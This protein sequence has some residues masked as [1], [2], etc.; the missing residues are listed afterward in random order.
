MSTLLTLADRLI[1]DAI[2]LDMPESLAYPSA[3]ADNEARLWLLKQY[4]PTGIQG[5][6]SRLSGRAIKEPLED[7]YR[8]AM[9]LC[10]LDLRSTIVD[11]GCG[12]GLQQV[13][14]R[15]FATYI[16]IDTSGTEQ[17]VVLQ[18]NARFLNGDFA[19]LVES[20]ELMVGGDMVAI[21]NGTLLYDEDNEAALKCIR[22]F[23][24]LVL[25]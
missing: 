4:G 13:F 14:F 9:F 16:G 11:I 18:P 2:P 20:G 19:K 22:Q 25:V 5:E 12:C 8:L 7:Y 17:P 24:R 21:A 10:K 3:P 6:L 1:K 23:N 15:D